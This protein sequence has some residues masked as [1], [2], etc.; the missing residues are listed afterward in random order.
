M[1]I[2]NIR[3][4]D[5]AVLIGDSEEKLQEV[6]ETLHGDCAARGLHI[7]L[8]RGKTEVMGLTKRSQNLILNISLKGRRI[9]Q[10]TSYKHLGAMVTKE[11]KYE[12]EVLK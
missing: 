12:G 9:S 5:D 6:V 7:N 11:D 8:D 10:V 4:A 3:Y 2:N 1:N